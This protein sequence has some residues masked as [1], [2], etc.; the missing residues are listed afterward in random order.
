MSGM[1][2]GGRQRVESAANRFERLDTNWR[3]ENTGG[4]SG[5]LLRRVTREKVGVGGQTGIA[6]ILVINLHINRSSV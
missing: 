6:A 1:Y 2:I 5:V 3:G 4:A